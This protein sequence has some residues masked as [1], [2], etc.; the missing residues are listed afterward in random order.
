MDPGET[1]LRCARWKNSSSLR[2]TRKL[3]RAKIVGGTKALYHLLPDPVFPTRTLPLDG[4]VGSVGLGFPLVGRQPGSWPEVAPAWSPSAC[5][6]GQTGLPKRLGQINRLVVDWPG[7]S[8]IA[9]P[10]E[11]ADL[12]GTTPPEGRTRLMPGIDCAGA[13]L[14]ERLQY[15]DGS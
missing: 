6:T 7:W 10:M 13:L 11:K 12:P 9:N 3:R 2:A 4:V 8:A 14:G 15:T 1:R 5:R